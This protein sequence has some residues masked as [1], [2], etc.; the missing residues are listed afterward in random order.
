MQQK[1][2][3]KIS[4]FDFTI[5]YKGGKGNDVSDF[6]FGLHKGQTVI[7]CVASAI[8]IVIPKWKSNLKQSGAQDSFSRYIITDFLN[9]DLPFQGKFVA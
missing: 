7:V 8:T 3:T 2:L 4:I 1:R 9:G 6:L 5:T